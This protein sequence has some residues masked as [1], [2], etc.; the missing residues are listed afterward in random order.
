MRD[1]N[2]ETLAK[3]L[4]QEPW[5]MDFVKVCLNRTNNHGHYEDFGRCV[6]NI[7]V[8]SMGSGQAE[9]SISETQ[10][11]FG[12]FR[13]HSWDIRMWATMDKLL[14]LLLEIPTGLTIDGKTYHYLDLTLVDMPG[15][16][17]GVQVRGHIY[18]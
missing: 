1:D 7:T 2:R 9:A 6:G 15:N 4:S 5:G 10:Y 13:D 14:I 18:I 12:T 3:N 16:A 8:E 17:G 11:D